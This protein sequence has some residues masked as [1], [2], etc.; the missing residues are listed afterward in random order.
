MFC[1]V[2]GAFLK[3]SR[4]EDYC[5]QGKSKQLKIKKYK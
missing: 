5:S 3:I 4:A 1:G 2:F